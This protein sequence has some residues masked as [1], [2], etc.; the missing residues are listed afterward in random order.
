MLFM[1]NGAGINTKYWNIFVLSANKINCSSFDT[2]HISLT[3]IV[4]KSG[5]KIEADGIG[6]CSE[7]K[8]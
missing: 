7:S 6:K 4:N 1:V 3:Y 8:N 2:L 5:P